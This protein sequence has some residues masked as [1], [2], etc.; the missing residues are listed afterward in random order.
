MESTMYEEYNYLLEN[1]TWDLVP[2]FSRRKLARCRW[3]YRTKTTTDGQLS[4]YKARLVVKG[5]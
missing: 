4:R 1:Q 5:F 2:L 3:V